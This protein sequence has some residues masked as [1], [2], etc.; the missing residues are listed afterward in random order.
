MSNKL[1]R[2]ALGDRFNL[3]RRPGRHDA[4]ALFPAAGAHINDI[5]CAADDIQVVLNDN[6]RRAVLDQ[7]AEHPSRVRTSSGCRPM[8]GSSKTN[9]VSPWA[10]PISLANFS[11]W[12]SPP[13][14]LGVSSPRVRVAKA[15]VL[16]HFLNAVSPILSL[17]KP[18]AP[19]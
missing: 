1:S 6:D 9:T 14:R 3:R 16:Q 8:V 13:E 11:R 10:L 18:S 2:P 7:R 19:C 17:C 5:I 15:Q 4:A 12:A